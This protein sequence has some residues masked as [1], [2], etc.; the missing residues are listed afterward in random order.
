[1]RSSSVKV[2]TR[3]DGTM[4]VF[5]HGELGQDMAVELRQLL[6]H[7]VRRVRPLRLVVDLARVSGLDPINV[8]SLAAAC[9][10]GDDHQVM[11]TVENSSATVAA[12]LNAAGVPQQRLVTPSSPPGVPEIG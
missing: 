7:T 11:V 5:L 8:G 4:V 10:L 2:G 6:V 12:Q 1:M 3:Q 9:A